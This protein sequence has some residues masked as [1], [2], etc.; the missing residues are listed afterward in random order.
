MR[1]GRTAP[2]EVPVGP[3]PR[4]GVRRHGT[5]G[6]I[7]RRRAARI[8]AGV[9]LVAVLTLAGHAAAATAA[10]VPP[11]SAVLVDT[12]TT[13][14]PDTTTTTV[15]PTTTTTSS[16][17]TTTTTRPT[18]T[19]TTRPTTTTTTRPTTT[20]TTTGPVKTTA[21][22]TPWGLIA[23]IVVL[24]ILI[25]LVIL[26]M[27]SRNRKSA[28]DAWRRRTL[29]AVSDAQLAREALLS[30][31]AVSDD[32]ELRGA[33]AVQVEK[34]SVALEQAGTSAPDPAAG[35]S[36]TTAA[37]ALRGLAFAIEADRLLRHGTGAPTGVQLAQADQARR[38]RDSELQGALTRLQNH[39]VPPDTKR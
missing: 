25:G 24:V 21:S 27:V 19:T 9:S 17:T 37:G 3:D 32:P 7:G 35:G 12:T 23:V 39:V 28:L 6:Q 16:T 4:H 30:P 5:P 36:A 31:T 22:K 13:T 15:A 2:G 33:V 34:A 29:P 14:V 38:D 10:T 11:V 20:T 8:A 18:T 1:H 26:L